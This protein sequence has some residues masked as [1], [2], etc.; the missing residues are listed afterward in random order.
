MGGILAILGYTVLTIAISTFPMTNQ[1]E[2]IDVFNNLL[3]AERGLQSADRIGHLDFTQHGYPLVYGGA[4]GLEHSPRA[5]LIPIGQAA[6]ANLPL[7]QA[8]DCVTGSPGLK[9]KPRLLAG[10]ASDNRVQDWACH[11]SKDYGGAAPEP[12][13]AMR[14]LSRS[15]AAPLPRCEGENPPRGG[16]E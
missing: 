13:V 2:P 10:L 6:S 5:P 14:P 1:L 9:C 8:P 4:G 3:M 11:C 15:T 16:G 12:S 7:V